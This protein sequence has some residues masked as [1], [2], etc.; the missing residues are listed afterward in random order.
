MLDDDAQSSSSFLQ[1]AALQA[2][3]GSNLPRTAIKEGGHVEAKMGSMIFVM[4]VICL[5]GRNIWEVVEVSD[6]VD[7]FRVTG[8]GGGG[9]GPPW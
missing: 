6:G 7:R 3:N 1:Q 5:G 4:L 2:A 9:G 8:G